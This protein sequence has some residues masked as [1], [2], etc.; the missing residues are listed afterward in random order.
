MR[1]RVNGREVDAPTDEHGWAVVRRTWRSGD[2]LTVSL[3]ATLRPEPVRGGTP[4]AIVRGPV[5]LAVSAAENN[6]NPAEL[7]RR[8]DLPGALAPDPRQPLTFHGPAGLLARPFYSY[9]QGQPYRL[10]LDPNAH[11]A[12]EAHFTPGWKSAPVGGQ[13]SSAEPGATAEFTFT[14][15]GVR[16]VGRRFDDAGVAQV[17]ID[18]HPLATVDQFGPGRGQTPFQWEHGG[19]T[20]G[21]HR[22]S[23]RVTGERPQASR[24][25]FVN[26]AAFEVTP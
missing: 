24:G 25:A 4:W 1:C 14:G 12:D 20:P 21:E 22:L 15:T 23:I 17:S 26:V 7:L 19:L 6:Q 16:W 10:Y 18:G 8:A 11:S 13:H 2:R 3:P 5:V 9:A